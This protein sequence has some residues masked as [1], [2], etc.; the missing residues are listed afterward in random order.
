[1][2]G[3]CA[4]KM[5][6]KIIE[7]VL[8]TKGQQNFSSMVFP[9]KVNKNKIALG[10][11]GALST[12]RRLGDNVRP[13]GFVRPGGMVRLGRFQTY[14]WISQSGGTRAENRNFT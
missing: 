14:D 7:G 4:L 1:M 8:L 12:A 2:S 10:T 6:A 5:S 9:K 3:N 11:G 13:L